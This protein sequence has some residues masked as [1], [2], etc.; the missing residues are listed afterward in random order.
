M[1]ETDAAEK[2]VEFKITGTELNIKIGDY[3]PLEALIGTWPGTFYFESV[4]VPDPKPKAVEETTDEAEES[5]D[6]FDIDFLQ[7]LKEQEGEKSS[8]FINIGQ[9]E[10]N[11]GFIWF[12]E[13]LEDL[14]EDGKLYFDYEHGLI[15]FSK[16]EDGFTI[17]GNL[18]AIYK[19]EETISLSGPLELTGMNGELDVDIIFES[20]R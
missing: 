8:S 4:K 3:P 10:E 11:Y 19:T 7:S 13:D 6:G 16:S 1:T 14:D 20:E 17:Q 2:V 15:K 9:V 5:C 18:R 12:G